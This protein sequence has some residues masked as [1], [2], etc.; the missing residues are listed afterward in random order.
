MK[1]SVL[2]KLS[3]G[4][5][6]I[7]IITGISGTALLIACLLVVSYDIHRFR[8]NQIEQ[9]SL[10]ADVLGQNSSAAMAFNDRQAASE[11]LTSSRFASS[12]MGICLY[13]N[14]GF[15]FAR[16]ARDLSWSCDSPP[17]RDGLFATFGE[18]TLVRPVITDG[19]RL[20]TVVVHSHLSELNPRLVRYAAIIFC[21]LLNSSLIALFLA[22]RL[23][24]LITRPVRRL[25]YIAHAV[26]RT[27]DYSL[28]AQVETQD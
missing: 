21:V 26:S 5:K 15:S 20:G 27:G 19:E 7:V 28:R 10:L 9:L 25:L 4:K 13:M 1:L 3:L 16:F 24:R 23:Q 11:I 6:L 22:M 12:V 2:D 8:A 14:D 17:P 18:L